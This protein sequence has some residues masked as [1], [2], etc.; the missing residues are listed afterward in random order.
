ML[1][2]EFR[3]DGSIIATSLLELKRGNYQ[4]KMT[5]TTGARTF[6]FYTIIPAAGRQKHHH[7]GHT[8][9]YRKQEKYGKYAGLPARVRGICLRLVRTILYGWR[10]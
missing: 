4:Q 8:S 2:Y 9:I 3:A 7:V 5:P 10:S 1:A 6:E